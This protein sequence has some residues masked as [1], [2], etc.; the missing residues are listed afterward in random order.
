MTS[1]RSG[2]AREKAFRVAISSKSGLALK[3]KRSNLPMAIAPLRGIRRVARCAPTRRPKRCV[4]LG[5]ISHDDEHGCAAGADR[6]SVCQGLFATLGGRT[7]LQGIKRRKA[8]IGHKM[9]RR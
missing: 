4:V 9:I 5:G 3:A 7:G 6:G 2:T 8:D 1:V